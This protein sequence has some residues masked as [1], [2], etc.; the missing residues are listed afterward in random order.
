MERA[1]P[2]CGR[3]RP[4]VRRCCPRRCEL[5]FGG[6]GGDAWRLV[7]L[8]QSIA[9]GIGS[10][11]IV[12][13]RNRHWLSSVCDWQARAHSSKLSNLLAFPSQPPQLNRLQVPLEASK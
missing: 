4:F 10:S 12:F 3:G 13:L 7:F 1:D 8:R 6:D 2:P 5:R 11:S 9:P